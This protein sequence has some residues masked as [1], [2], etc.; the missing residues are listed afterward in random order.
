MTAQKTDILAQ[1]SWL[2]GVARRLVF[3]ALVLLLP[4]LSVVTAFGIVPGT[5]PADVELT[6]VREP[7]D[8][9]EP[10]APVEL[11]ARFV[12]QERVLR[13]DTVAALFDRL[14]VTAPTPIHSPHPSPNTRL[15]S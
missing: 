5:A 1:R 6:L 12:S 14:G 15:I 11:P 7:L 8:L 9:P 4:A 2:P 13:G 10:A 3:G